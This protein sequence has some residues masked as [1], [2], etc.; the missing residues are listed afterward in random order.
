M[1]RK[2]FL[3]HPLSVGETYGE[4]MRT[5]WRFGSSMV[6]AGAACCV[7]AAFPTLF[8]RTASDRVKKLYAEMRAR[9]PAFNE[10]R[11]AF[12][13]PEWQLEYEI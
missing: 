13:E 5:A 4:H 1:I 9:Q 3:D 10:R 8:P 7:H 12:E 11:P 2:L 6:V